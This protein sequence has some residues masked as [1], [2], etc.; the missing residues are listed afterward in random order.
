MNINLEYIQTITIS[1]LKQILNS[2]VRNKA[3]EELEKQKSSHSKVKKLKHYKL[4]MQN[5]LKPN[6]LKISKDEAITIFKMRSR[7][8]E[9][10]KNYRGKYDNIECDLCNEEEES[11]EH[12]LKCKEI[13]KNESKVEVPEYD[14]LLDGSV[15]FQLEIAKMFN[16]NMKKKKEILD[17]R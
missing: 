12:I 17:K 5:Y 15:K 8:T 11:Q 7:M 13:M 1:K 2:A 10:K 16:E 14:K 3:F 9:V 4:E 6:Q